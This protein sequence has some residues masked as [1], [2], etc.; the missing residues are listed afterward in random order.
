MDNIGP[1]PRKHWMRDHLALPIDFVD[2]RILVSLVLAGRCFGEAI[3]LG[4]MGRSIRCLL[5][6]TIPNYFQDAAIFRSK[7]HQDKGS[8]L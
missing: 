3:R 5:D 6:T 2:A 4:P 1:F 7:S 8:Y